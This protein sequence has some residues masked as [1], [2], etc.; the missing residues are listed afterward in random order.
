M[1]VGRPRRHLLT[2]KG[3][4]FSGFRQ[5]GADP[6][7]ASQIGVRAGPTDTDLEGVPRNRHNLRAPAE[8]IGKQYRL[9]DVPPC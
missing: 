8:G 7:Y 5:S 1:D 9:P 6:A 4:D 3:P 2:I